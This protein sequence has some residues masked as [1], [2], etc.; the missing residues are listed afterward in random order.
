MRSYGNPVWMK[1]RLHR[2][3]HFKQE[4][5]RTNDVLGARS[6][7]PCS[8]RKAK[9]WKTLSNSFLY[10]VIVLDNLALCMENLHTMGPYHYWQHPRSVLSPL[11][12]SSGCV[13]NGR[14]TFCDW[15]RSRSISSPLDSSSSHVRS[16]EVVC[17]AASIPSRPL[18]I[19]PQG[20][21]W[22]SASANLHD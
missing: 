3:R 7:C 20:A 22:V 19:R 4:D 12:S 17:P 1:Q 10:K 13:E 5:D 16:S 15:Q 11:N 2:G 14:V 21:A 6:E 9:S 18:R 8:G